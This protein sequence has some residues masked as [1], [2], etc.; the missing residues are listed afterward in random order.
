MTGETDA[1]WFNVLEAGMVKTWVE[2]HP[3]ELV[4]G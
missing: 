2:S 1:L 4:Q 3:W